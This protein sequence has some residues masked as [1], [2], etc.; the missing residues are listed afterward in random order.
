MDGGRL[1]RRAPRLASSGKGGQFP[2]EGARQSAPTL[3]PRGQAFAMPWGQ[4]VYPPGPN[5]PQA[6]ARN[7]RPGPRQQHA[8]VAAGSSAPPLQL[9]ERQKQHL[10]EQA[11][12]AVQPDAPPGRHI[13]FNC[14]TAGRPHNHLYKACA[15]TVCAHCKWVGRTQ[16]ECI[17]DFV[18]EWRYER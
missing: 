1:A 15:W 10:A 17:R 6:G 8:S 11:A 12:Q 7:A 9:R 18:P 2:Q 14:R 16:R 5:M 13:C 3:G 4:T